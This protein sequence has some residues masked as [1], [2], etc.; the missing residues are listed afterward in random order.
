[1]AE[2]QKAAER[3][4]SLTRQL[5]AFSRKQVLRPQVIRLN[6][7]IGELFSLLRRLIGEDIELTQALDPGLGMA[8]VDPGQFE[9][10]VINLAVNARDA[11]PAGGRLSLTTR[12][13]RLGGDGTDRDPEAPSGE[14]VVVEVSDTGQGMDETIQASI[15]EPFFTTKEAGKGTGLGLAMVYGFVS[16]SG[17]HIQVDSV[18][19]RGTTFRLYLP[20]SEE[21]ETFPV[22]ARQEYRIPTGDETILLVEDEEAVRTLAGLVL[23]SYGY[24]VLVATDGQEGLAIAREHPGPIHVVVTDMVMPRLSGRQLADQ[25]ARERPKIPILFMSGYTDDAVLQSGVVEAGENF[26]PKPVSPLALARKVRQILDSEK[27]PR[28]VA[29][30]PRAG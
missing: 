11:M 18:P 25:L 26:I 19:G 5:L 23:Q 3:A 24:K 16:Q 14:Y 4:V 7:M 15:F 21:A 12:N 9:Q 20:R 2:I 27:A 17:G 30:L 22:R 1:L 13:A 6:Q 10:A 29:S 8:R 28:E